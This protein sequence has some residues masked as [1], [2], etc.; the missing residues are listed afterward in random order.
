MLTQNTPHRQWSTLVPHQVYLVVSIGDSSSEDALRATM[1]YD[2]E[3]LARLNESDAPFV[4]FINDVRQVVGTP[5]IAMVQRME[6]IRHPRF[7]YYI[8]LGAMPNVLLRTVT[9]MVTSMGR[10]RYSDVIHLEDAYS[11]LLSKDPAL[12]SLE[13]WSLPTNDSSL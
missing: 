3:C 6:C 12:P 9:G 11:L 1:E 8:T 2:Q 10:I 5:P 4:H 13:M 7:G